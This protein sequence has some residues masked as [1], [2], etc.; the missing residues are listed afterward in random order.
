VPQSER[1]ATSPPLSTPLAPYTRCRP[2]HRPS[3]RRDSAVTPPLFSPPGRHRPPCR[4]RA[5]A[6]PG[7]DHPPAPDAP[8]PVIRIA[9]DEVGQSIGR[10]GAPT[11]SALAG[12]RVDRRRRA[13]RRGRPRG[14]D[15]ERGRDEQSDP[16]D[17]RRVHGRGRRG[18]GA[19]PN[20]ACPA[21]GSGRASVPRG[22]HVD[23][24]LRVATRREDAAGASDGWRRL[25]AWT[26]R[27]RP[28]RP[29][30]APAAATPPG[31]PPRARPP[32]VPSPMG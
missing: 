22:T 21:I 23:L 26:P 14:G 8:S 31:S 19:R 17:A 29:H 10:P 1:T 3:I 15:R 4:W 32:A 2:V 18:C 28:T 25:M 6:N 13:T 12:R 27:P 20:G 5:D 11:P 9:I 16:A 24:S 30:G 7:H